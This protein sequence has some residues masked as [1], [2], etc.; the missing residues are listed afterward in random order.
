M[1]RL[2]SP[3]WEVDDWLAV[4]P[5]AKLNDVVDLVD[6]VDLAVPGD[7]LLLR[8]FVLLVLLEDSVLLWSSR[9]LLL[10]SSSSAY[11]IKAMQ[12][13]CWMWDHILV[14]REAPPFDET[15]TYGLHSRRRKGENALKRNGSK[16]KGSDDVGNPHFELGWGGWLLSVR[17]R[18]W[19]EGWITHGSIS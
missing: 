11:K 19:E 17:R 2:G 1:A 15:E 4:L 7:L 8:D 5:T 16:E 12:A 3:P 6:L 13:A 18:V 9:L 10:G 14:I